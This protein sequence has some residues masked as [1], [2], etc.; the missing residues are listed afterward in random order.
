MRGTSQEAHIAAMTANI[1]KGR[2]CREAVIRD[3]CRIVRFHRQTYQEAMPKDMNAKRPAA[4]R[5]RIDGAV[6][7]SKGSI[8]D[9]AI[10]ASQ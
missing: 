4:T 2:R 1:T 5:A 7:M 9:E 3:S 10:L 6:Q 8:G